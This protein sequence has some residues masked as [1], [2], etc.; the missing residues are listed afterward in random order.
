MVHA[1]QLK[2]QVGLLFTSSP[3]SEV[4]EWFAD[5]HPPTFLRSGTHATRTYTIPSGPILQHHASPPEPFPH[6]EEPQLRKLGLHTSMV[7]G[8]PTLDREHVVCKEG[9]TLSA[10]QAQILKLVGIKMG[11]FRMQL[12]WRWQKDGGEVVEVE[13]GEGDAVVGNEPGEKDDGEAEEEVMSE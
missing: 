7:R 10:E 6:N 13:G 1:Q 2:G 4:T 5:F 3:P 8:V 11:E 9:E 12:R